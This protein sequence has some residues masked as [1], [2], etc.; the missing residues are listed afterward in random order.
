MGP[1]QVGR[2]WHEPAAAAA[3][4][5]PTGPGVGNTRAVAPGVAGGGLRA[6]GIAGV[7][8]RHSGGSLAVRQVNNRFCFT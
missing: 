7:F 6:A 1:G 4:A 5:A 2:S 8:I 3:A